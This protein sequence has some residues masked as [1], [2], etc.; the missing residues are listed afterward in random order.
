MGKKNKTK[1]VLVSNVDK[2]QVYA[3]VGAEGI[4]K[5]SVSSY[6]FH[7]KPKTALKYI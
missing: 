4:W 7:H 6:Q 2:G 5:I 1:H 3:C